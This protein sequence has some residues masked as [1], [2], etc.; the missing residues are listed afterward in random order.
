MSSDNPEFGKIAAQGLVWL[1]EQYGK[2][3]SDKA[4]GQF[5]RRWLQF[6]WPEAELKYRQRLMEQHTTVRILGNP[7][8]IRVDEIYT[9]VFVLDQLSAF[10]RFS[11]E[12]L[13]KLPLDRN[14]LKLEKKISALRVAKEENRLYILGKPGAGKTT[15][16]RH[17]T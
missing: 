14:A 8:P 13:P 1:W 6:K 11:I 10:Q 7:T 9:D 16:L 17:I 15:F 5:K 12:N 4:V 2:P 3:I